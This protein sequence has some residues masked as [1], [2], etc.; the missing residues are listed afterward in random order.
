[1]TVGADAAGGVARQSEL[2]LNVFVSYARDDFEFTDQ[3]VA[4]LKACGF[5]PSLDRQGVSAGEKWREQ[6]G[7]LILAAD[8]VVFVLTPKS[9]V[10]PECLWEFDEA[11]RLTARARVAR[12]D[13]GAGQ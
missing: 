4:G 8:S 7:K 12:P 13:D 11:Q 5:D 10:S 2:P 1:M 6:L 3:L 9:I